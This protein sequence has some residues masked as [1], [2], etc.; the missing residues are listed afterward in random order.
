MKTEALRRNV[1]E[2]DGG[3]HPKK[4]PAVRTDALLASN[5]TGGKSSE[6]NQQL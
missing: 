2:T 4:V 1:G 6:R 5:R 3:A